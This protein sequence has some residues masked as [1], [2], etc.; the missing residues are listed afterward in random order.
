MNKKPK[1]R[2]KHGLSP[3]YMQGCPTCVVIAM[4][5]LDICN[6]NNIDGRELFC[7][8]HEAFSDKAAWDAALARAKVKI[9]EHDAKEAVA[10]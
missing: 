5:C 4:T 3:V 8:M 6:D 9:A 2:C 10:P 7:M 1:E